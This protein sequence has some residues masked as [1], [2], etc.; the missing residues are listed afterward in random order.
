MDVEDWFHLEYFNKVCIPKKDKIQSNKDGITNY[1]NLLSKYNIRGNFFI[2]GN[3]INSI[4]EEIY[5]IHQRGHEIGVHSFEHKRPITMGK[6]EFIK[7]LTK[8]INKLRYL[9]IEPIG[10]RAP[11]FALG[12]KLLEVLSSNFKQ[13][14]FDSSFINQKEHPLYTPLDL[15]KLDFL[16]REKG[17][18][19]KNGFFEFEVSTTNF[20]GIN[21]PIS[22]GGYIRILPWFVYKFLLIKYLKTGKFYSFYVHPFE[23]SQKDIDL[24][25]GISLIKKIRFNY[26]R[27]K[28]IKRIEKTIQLLKKFNYSFH[29]Y[30]ELAI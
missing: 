16:E 20:L 10:Y 18:F 1:L 21:I 30:S 6:D 26:N 28:T 25:K 17:I 7:D 13:L 27:K 15:N 9:G 5:T 19:E 11:C 8:N 24:P 2:V 22:G 29:T 23:T 12:N 14:L 3:F 4:S